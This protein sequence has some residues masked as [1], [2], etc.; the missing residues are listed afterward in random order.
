MWVVVVCLLLFPT[1]LSFLGFFANVTFQLPVS[2]LRLALT[3][4]LGSLE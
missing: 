4:V 3:F 2:A 1:Y